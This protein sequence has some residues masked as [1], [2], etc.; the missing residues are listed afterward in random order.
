MACSLTSIC[1]HKGRVELEALFAVFEG[2]DGLHQLDV[3][4]RSVR[5]KSFVFWISAQTFFEFFDC[6]GELTTLEEFIACV[7][8][9]FSFLRIEICFLFSFFLFLLY[10]FHRVSDMN[11]VI[12]DEGSPVHLDRFFEPA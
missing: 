9:L 3:G 1:L 10:A 6:L 5:V 2:L 12:F 7:F 4:S 11:I 8:V